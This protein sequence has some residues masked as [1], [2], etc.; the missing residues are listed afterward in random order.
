MFETHN[1]DL[2]PKGWGGLPTLRNDVAISFMYRKSEAGD[3]RRVRP[4]ISMKM[5]KS[6]PSTSANIFEHREKYSP[7]RVPG[8]GYPILF[9][10]SFAL[11]SHEDAR[12][13][14]ATRSPTVQVHGQ[15]FAYLA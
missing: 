3:P 10:V 7:V 12:L 4:K 15:G 13:Y 5:S 11:R 8:E 9:H 14:A 6:V 1:K 2:S